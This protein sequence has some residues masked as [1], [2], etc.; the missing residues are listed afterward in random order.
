MFVLSRK[1]LATCDSGKADFVSVTL[2]FCAAVSRRFF[3][4]PLARII[5]AT[6]R[7]FKLSDEHKPKPL[8]LLTEQLLGSF[9][10]FW[11]LSFPSFWP[12]VFGS[13]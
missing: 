6:T 1:V 4:A 7:L 5:P 9:G 11:G 10:T 13:F 12:R 2:S 8:C 3:G